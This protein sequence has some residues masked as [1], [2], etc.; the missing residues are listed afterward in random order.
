MTPRRSPGAAIAFAERSLRPSIPGWIA[1]ST[2]GG[3]A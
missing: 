1:G 2:V 3:P